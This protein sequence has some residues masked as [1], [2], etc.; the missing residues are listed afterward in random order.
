[1]IRDPSSHVTGQALNPHIA[2][3]PLWYIAQQTNSPSAAESRSSDDLQP[4]SSTSDSSDNCVKIH[5]E[6]GYIDYSDLTHIISLSC[7]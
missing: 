5:H 2:K 3:M 6:C 4:L 1:M 7:I